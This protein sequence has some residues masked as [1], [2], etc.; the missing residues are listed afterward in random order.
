MDTT[1]LFIHSVVIGHL[2]CFH[3]LAVMNSAGINTCVQDFV[4]AYCPFFRADMF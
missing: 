3:L 4:A 1:P 2:G